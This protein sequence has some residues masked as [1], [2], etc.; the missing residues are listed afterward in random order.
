LR[1][2]DRAYRI[3]MRRHQRMIKQDIFDPDYVP[4]LLQGQSGR[5]ANNSLPTIG[6]GRR[7][8]NETKRGGRRKRK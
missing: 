1:E 7:N 5:L 6:Y 2:D 8:P 4:A 3:G